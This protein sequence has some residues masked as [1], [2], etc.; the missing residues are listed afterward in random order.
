MV[1]RYSTDLRKSVL[2]FVNNGGSKAE[3]ERTFGVSRQAIYNWLEAEAPFTYQKP[4][5]KGP[6]SIDYDALGKHVADFPD[7]TLVERAD[8]FGVSKGCISYAFEKLN[9]TR[10]KRR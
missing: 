3:A 6:R 8:H 7:K 5:P 10:K 9:I 1:M 4:G 2:D